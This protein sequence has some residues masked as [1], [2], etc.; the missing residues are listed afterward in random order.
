MDIDFPVLVV[1]DDDVSR[2]IVQKYLRKAGFEVVTA[3][4]GMEALSLFEQRFCP[5]II[6]DWMMPE[7]SGPELC[8]KIREKKTDGYVFVLLVTARNSKN[9]IVSGLEAGADDYLTKPIPRIN[10]CIRI[11]RL[12]QSLKHANEEIR[13]LSI[14]DPLTGCYN[15]TYLGEQLPLELSRSKRYNHPL[16]VVMADI[17]HFKRVN[18][19][20]G[21][22]I[23]DLVLKSFAEC[24][25]AQLR[26]NI[27][28][29]V[30]FGGEEFLIILPETDRAGAKN[31]AER[32]RM[33][34]NTMRIPSNVGNLYITASFGGATAGFANCRQ[35]DI[36]MEQLIDRADEQLYFAKREGRDR[37]NAIEVG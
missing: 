31:L 20:F 28:W 18:D 13:L 37:I 35:L 12:E 30:R 4:N 2:A 33:H 10:T 19:T 15:R 34:L 36:T 6:T 11:L 32:L 5:I 17:D 8:R 1:D 3:R 27:D 16:S 14:T 26:E 24:I 22:Q 25:R 29:M 9:D 23:G 21:H 7:I